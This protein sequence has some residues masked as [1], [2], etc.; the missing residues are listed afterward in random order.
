MTTVGVLGGGQLGRMLGLAGLPLGLRFRFLDP[1]EASP[2][3]AVGEHVRASFAAPQRLS[4]FRAGVDVVTY[5]FEGVPAGTAEALSSVVPVRPAPGVLRGMQ[6]RLEQKRFVRSLGID[7]ASFAPVHDRASL[8][9]AL[10]EVG[11]PSRLKARRGGYDGRGQARIDRPEE[12]TAAWR[13]LGEVPAL[14]ERHVPFRREIAILAVRDTRGAHRLYPLVETRQSDGVLVR[15]VA[16]APGIDRAL[17]RQAGAIARRILDALDYVGVLAIECFELDG[18][19]IVNELAPRVHNSGHWTTE[20]AATSQFENHLRAVVGFP[21]G[22]TRARGVSGL[23]N[24]LGDVP[25]RA[26]VLAV[27]GTHLHLY[28]KRPLPGRKL[29]H[30]TVRAAGHGQLRD[31]L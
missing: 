13:A 19:L 16:P 8:E 3:A 12:A 5:E 10:R 24:L 18:R 17:R 11:T 14:L 26:A 4:E 7:V 29:G 2:A 28:G 22:S 30:V 20:G 21:L 23:V 1:A 9:A 6:D 15:A 31:R 27:P 25:E